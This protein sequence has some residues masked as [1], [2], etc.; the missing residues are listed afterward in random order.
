MAPARKPRAKA[1][2]PAITVPQDAGQADDAIRVIG[3]CQ[4]QLLMTE[5]EYQE[6][7]AE[8]KARYAEQAKPFHDEIA[9]RTEGLRMWAE[10]NRASLTQGGRKKTVP[11]ASGEISWR[12]RPPAVRIAGA[13]AVIER[14]KALKLLQFLRVTEEPNREAM[15]AD[16]AAARA[17]EGVSI[18]SAGEV[19]EVK[20]AAEL[21]D[22]LPPVTTARPEAA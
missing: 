17:I 20:P 2:A 11:F 9:M 10:A 12:A 3:A 14:I 18:A 5:T 21:L 19:F 15:L 13:A 7:A 16:P 8:L 22:P 4:R 6:R 1:A